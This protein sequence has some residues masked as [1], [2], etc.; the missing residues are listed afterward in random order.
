MKNETYEEIGY[1]VKS[2][3]MPLKRGGIAAIR[4]SITRMTKRKF[5]FREGRLIVYFC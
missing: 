5:C 2:I 1:L 4:H 3:F